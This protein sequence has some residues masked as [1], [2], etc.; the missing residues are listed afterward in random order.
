MCAFRAQRRVCL[1]DFFSVLDGVAIT[2][3]Y[4]VTNGS[5]ANGNT[6]ELRLGAFH[7]EERLPAAS[8]CNSDRRCR[9]QTALF[10]SLN[11]Q[12]QFHPQTGEH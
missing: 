4:R 12:L 6:N 5:T 10:S 1:C 9:Q 2:Y 8:Y 11:D 3:I 7:W